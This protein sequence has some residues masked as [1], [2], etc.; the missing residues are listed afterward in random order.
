VNAHVDE[1]IAVYFT[2]LAALDNAAKH[3]A[4]AQVDVSLSDCGSALHFAVRDSGAGFDPDRT[5]HGTGIANMRDRIAAV[6][7]TL[8]VDPTPGHRTRVRGSV[9]APWLDA[10]AT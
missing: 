6:G 7:G 2:C 8:T 9:P 1:E 10:A 3:A 4:S 5:L